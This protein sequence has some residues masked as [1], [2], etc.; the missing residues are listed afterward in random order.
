MRW[1]YA[2]LMAVIPTGILWADTTYT[3]VPEG[4][5]TVKILATSE[6]ADLAGDL[7]GRINQLDLKIKTEQ[8]N[9]VNLQAEKAKIEAELAS[10]I[11]AQR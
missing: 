9:I 6:A 5:Q 4:V 10:L 11:N 8:A 2:V 1:R 3:K 7:S